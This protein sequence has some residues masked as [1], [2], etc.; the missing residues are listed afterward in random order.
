[1][2]IDILLR[3]G[4]NGKLRPNMAEPT[5]PSE[6]KTYQQA[7]K[8]ANE[9]NSHLDKFT[10]SVAR[11]SQ[12]DNGENDLVSEKGVVST[13]GP[14][15]RGDSDSLMQYQTLRFDT[16]NGNVGSYDNNIGGTIYRSTT[17]AESAH[18]RHYT[19]DERSSYTNAPLLAFQS[20]TTVSVPDDS[21]RFQRE[22]VSLR[23]TQD[24]VVVY[25]VIQEEQNFFEK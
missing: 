24:G 8:A 20:E 19:M 9:A 4:T 7:L 16:D 22:R 13:Y 5:T 10:A 23:E 3:R 2:N 11:L 18:G 15:Q 1:M 25:Q 12:T 17:D 6:A 21:S 14:L